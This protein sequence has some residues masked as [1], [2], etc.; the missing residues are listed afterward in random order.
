MEP[1][2]VGIKQLYRELPR[3][4]RAVSRGQSFMVMKHTTPIFKISPPETQSKKKYVLADLFALRFKG[5][6]PDLSKKI[7]D[8][9]YG[10]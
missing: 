2:I 1:T 9:V 5:G 3:I 6:D 10:V 4:T 8:I 7:D